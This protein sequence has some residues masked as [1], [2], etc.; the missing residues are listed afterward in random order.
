[1][2]GRGL[3]RTGRTNGHDNDEVVEEW[4]VDGT[5]DHEGRA[6]VGVDGNEDTGHTAETTG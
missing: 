5:L 3:R 6:V 2:R 1:M 4:V